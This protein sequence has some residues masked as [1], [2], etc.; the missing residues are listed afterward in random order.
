MARKAA[1]HRYRVDDAR[2]NVMWEGEGDDYK[3]VPPEFRDRPGDGE[4]AHYIYQVADDGEAVLIGVQ[5]SE[6]EEAELLA[7][8]YN[9]QESGTDGN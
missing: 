8:Q 7:A 2:G 1:A 6:A 3:A 4:P 5:R 9:D